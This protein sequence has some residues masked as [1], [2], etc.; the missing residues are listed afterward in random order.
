MSL[1]K[2]SDIFISYAKT[3]L[4]SCMEMIWGFVDTGADACL[5]PGSLAI[6]L[7]HDLKGDGVKSTTNIG[8]GQIAIPVYSHTFK[9]ELLSPDRKKVIWASED[10]EVECSETEPPIL[11]G[12]D[13]FLK[14]FKLIVDYPNQEFTLQWK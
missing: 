14:N 1:K 11:I 10:V 4:S 8:I 2:G 12:V 7:N 9:L 3:Y 13:N 5:F 6:D